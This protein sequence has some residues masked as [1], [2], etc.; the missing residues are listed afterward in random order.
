M[1]PTPII[2]NGE[3]KNI[4]AADVWTGDILLP[5]DKI[6]TQLSR[7]DD[8]NMVITVADVKPNQDVG[9][10]LVVEDDLDVTCHENEQLSVIRGRP[11]VNGMH[12][13]QIDVRGICH[14]YAHPAL[15]QKLRAEH[16]MADQQ[17]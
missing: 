6:V 1:S 12:M 11:L 5:G 9:I 13:T 2:G 17:R 14:G 7:K 15:E 8:G 10:P 16:R 3:T 4:R